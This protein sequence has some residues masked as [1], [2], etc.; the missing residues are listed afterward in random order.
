MSSY[1]YAV[2]MNE[3]SI[4]NGGGQWLPDAKVQQIKDYMS[5]PSMTSMFRNPN[6]T[7]G[8]YGML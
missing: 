2:M 4:N 5:N 1:D 3:G 8:R 7:I 6:T